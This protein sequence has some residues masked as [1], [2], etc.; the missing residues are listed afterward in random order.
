MIDYHIH[1]AK[2]AARIDM[3]ALDAIKT[4][5]EVEVRNS[6]CVPSID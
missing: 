2:A 1:V 4:S 6:L 5:K 3:V